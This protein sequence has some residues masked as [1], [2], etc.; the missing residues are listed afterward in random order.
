MA[1]SWVVILRELALVRFFLQEILF[2]RDD[3]SS[4]TKL[5]AL[6]FARPTRRLAAGRIFLQKSYQDCTVNLTYIMRGLIRS[7][8]ADAS[9][10]QIFST[11]VIFSTRRDTCQDWSKF[12]VIRSANAEANGCHIFSIRRAFSTRRA[13]RAKIIHSWKLFVIERGS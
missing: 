9:G 4:K 6:R 7:S 2:T 11:E 12:A 5:H 1:V 10:C 13:K 8:A 3:I